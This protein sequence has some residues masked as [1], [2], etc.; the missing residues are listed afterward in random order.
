MHLVSF[1]NKRKWLY[2]A[3]TFN[4]WISVKV[5][6]SQKQIM[7]SSILPKNEQ[8]ITIL[9][10][11]SLENT[12]ESDFSFVLWKNWRHHNLLLRLTDLYQLYDRHDTQMIEIIITKNCKIHSSFFFHLLMFVSSKKL[13]HR[14]KKSLHSFFHILLI[15]KYV[16]LFWSH[17]YSSVTLKQLGQILFEFAFSLSQ[18][19]TFTKKSWN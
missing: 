12:Q 4:K 15:N 5:R 7:V 16:S 1:F 17:F 14:C 13:P 6:K 10:I 11:F 9:S 2:E 8:K 3:S 18:I 19:R